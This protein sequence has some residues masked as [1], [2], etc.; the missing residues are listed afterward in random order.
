MMEFNTSMKLAERKFQNR[1]Y[2]RGYCGI[3][4]ANFGYNFNSTK[5]PKSNKR[6]DSPNSKQPKSKKQK[7]EEA[8]TK[9]LACG[10]KVI[11]ELVNNNVRKGRISP[12]KQALFELEEACSNSSTPERTRFRMCEELQNMINEYCKRYNVNF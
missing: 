9:L 7:I 1:L 8:E 5:D 11:E 2:R 3:Q 4:L 10:K 12:L 6:K